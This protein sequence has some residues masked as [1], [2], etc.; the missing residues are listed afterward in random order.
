MNQKDA[1]INHKCQKGEEMGGD[2]V[3]KKSLSSSA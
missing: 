2:L 3:R 1:K